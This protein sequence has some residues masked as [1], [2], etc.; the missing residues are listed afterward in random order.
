MRAPEIVFVYSETS[1]FDAT[2][3]GFG[4]VS[5]IGTLMVH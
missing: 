5:T 2:E 4:V 3:Q 1:D